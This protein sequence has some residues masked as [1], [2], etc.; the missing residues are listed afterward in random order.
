MEQEQKQSEQSNQNTNVGGEPETATILDRADNAVKKLE[1]LEAIEKRLDE[2]VNRIESA[3]ARIIMGGRSQ[4]GQ[5]Q[6]TP[7][8]IQQEKI[9]EEVKRIV[10][11]Y[12]R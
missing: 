10:S 7:E 2:K 11:G 8:Q 12:K 1:A 4:A 9:D 3:A 6:K 5:A